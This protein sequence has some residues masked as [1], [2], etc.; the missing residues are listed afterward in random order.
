MK[1]SVASQSI[2][3]EVSALLFE[4]CK[5]IFIVID[6]RLDRYTSFEVLALIKAEV[7]RCR[8]NPQSAL[9]QFCKPFH[10]SPSERVG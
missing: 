9:H 5:K 2:K 1:F 4:V 10:I 7:I 6:C 8:E 3:A